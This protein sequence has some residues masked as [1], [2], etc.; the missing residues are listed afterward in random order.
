MCCCIDCAFTFNEEEYKIIVSDYYDLSI[1][2]D[3]ANI[4]NKTYDI[5]KA[6][7]YKEKSPFTNDVTKKL[8]EYSGPYNDFYGNDIRTLDYKT[9]FAFIK[10]APNDWLLRVH[11]SN[12]DIDV[13][14][15]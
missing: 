6:E 4:E 2:N 3:G 7:L 10:T 1:L 11:M 9:I 15:I 14:H 12:G 5:V 8:N 13:I